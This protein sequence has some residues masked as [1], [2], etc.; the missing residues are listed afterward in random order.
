MEKIHLSTNKKKARTENAALIFEDEAS[1]RQDSTLH[2]TWSR[3]GQQPEVPVTGRR[4]SVKIFGCVDILSSK[5]LY[6]KDTVFN[7]KTYICFLEKIARNFHRQRLYYIQDNASYHKDAEVWAWFS[8]NRYWFTVYNLPPYSPQDNAAEP[9]WKYTRKV[10]THNRYFED[11][12]EIIGV[13]DKVFKKIQ[14][15]PDLIKGYLKPFQ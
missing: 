5:F 9:L 11:K 3:R 15:D 8:D 1:F 14:K 2:A 10:G 4:E 13:L 6:Q 7:A 12:I